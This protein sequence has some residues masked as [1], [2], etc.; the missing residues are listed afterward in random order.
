[1]SVYLPYC[2]E[3]I[4]DDQDQQ[5]CLREVASLAKLAVKVRW[6]KEFRGSIEVDQLS[7]G[8]GSKKTAS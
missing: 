8:A 6:F 7:S 1:M 2:D 5:N 4:S 3:L